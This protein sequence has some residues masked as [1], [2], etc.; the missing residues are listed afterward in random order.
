MTEPLVRGGLPETPEELIEKLD[1]LMD[2]EAAAERLMALGLRAI[3]WLERF[4]LDGRARTVA[5]PRCRAA[6]ALGE[7]GAW[8]SL[9]Q[10]FREY[11]RPEDAA[12]LFAEDAVRSAAAEELGRWKSEEVYQTL[13]EAAKN[14]ITDGLIH[15]LSE[16]GRAESIPVFFSAL[17]DDLCRA[18][19]IDALRRMPEETRAYAILSLR[20]AA[21]PS[22]YLPS[23]R[24]RRRATLQLLHEV[25]VAAEAWREMRQFL[26]DPDADSVIAVVATGFAIAPESEHAALIDA[27]FRIALHVN[28]AQEDEVT[29]LLDERA[30]PARRKARDLADEAARKGESPD[31][32]VPRWRILRHLLGDIWTD[33][34]GVAAKR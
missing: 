31:W 30:Q 19:A 21:G 10:Y 32:L 11:Q 1:S 34:R 6:H 24:R 14:R 13:L 25:G 2:G 33:A 17:E 5:L 18:E 4:L 8:Q 16:F 28:W 20:D 7:L 27:L 29:R 12:V 26:D 23:A 9:V 22:P 3:H 15:A